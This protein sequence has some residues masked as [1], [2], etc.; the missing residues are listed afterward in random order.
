MPCLL[1]QYC[2]NGSAN[3]NKFSIILELIK[4]VS[5]GSIAD[6]VHTGLM[7]DDTGDMVDSIKLGRG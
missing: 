1:G 6:E 5:C 3:L 2:F 4:G 7:V